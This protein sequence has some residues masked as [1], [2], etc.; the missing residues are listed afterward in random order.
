MH[1]DI[2]PDSWLIDPA[3]LAL[4]IA[5]DTKAADLSVL[6]VEPLVSWCSY[7]VGQHGSRWDLVSLAL[8][9][10]RAIVLLTCQYCMGS[11]LSA[12]TATW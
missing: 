8:P 5:D 4:Q 11:R 6:H 7:M 9:P 10:S 12:G 3:N 2:M 1:F